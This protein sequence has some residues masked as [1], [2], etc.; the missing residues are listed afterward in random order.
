MEV[1]GVGVGGLNCM[2]FFLWFQ[3]NAWRN[4]FH[5]KWFDSLCIGKNIL[6]MLYE[7]IIKGLRLS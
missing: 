7:I 6:K 2:S 1:A 4:E 3:V 5:P